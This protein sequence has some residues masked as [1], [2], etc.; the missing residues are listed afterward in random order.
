MFILSGCTLHANFL[1]SNERL[2]DAIVGV[3]YNAQINISGGNVAILADSKGNRVFVGHIYP[4]DMGLYLQHCNDDQYN[5][6]CVQIRGV[7]IKEG[8]IKVR[9][10]GFFNVAMLQTSNDFDKTY[11]IMVG[12]QDG[13]H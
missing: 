4:P 8:L 3:P 9:V 5:N 6:N 12:N 7:P 13:S 10:S 2:N 11:T 1:P